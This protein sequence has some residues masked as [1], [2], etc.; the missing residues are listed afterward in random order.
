MWEPF[1]SAPTNTTAFWRGSPNERGTLNILSICIITLLL[2]AYTSLHLDIPKYDKAGWIHQLWRRLLWVCVG[3]GAPEFVSLAKW[4]TIHSTAFKLVLTPEQVA[5]IAFR[6][7]LFAR[8]LE[9][10]MHALT[11]N[12]LSNSD[13]TTPRSTWPISMLRKS[14][15]TTMAT[16]KDVEG[17]M[18][19]GTSSGPD[20]LLAEPGDR[21]SANT[22][23]TEALSDRRNIWTRVHSH[24]ALMGGFVFEADEM[25]LTIM[26]ADRKRLTLTPVALRKIAKNA[27]ELLPDLS[28]EAI[29]DK[30]K[31]NGLAKFLV[32]VQA[33]WFIAQT[34]GRLGTSLPISLLEMN[35][36]LHAFCCL[37]IYLAWWH[38]PLDIEEPHVIH[39]AN[40]YAGKVCAWMMVKDKQHGYLLAY[41]DDSKGKSSLSSS[42]RLRLV[43]EDDLAPE[44]NAEMGRNNDPA[45]M[46]RKRIAISRQHNSQEGRLEEVQQ[47]DYTLAKMS[48]KN[49]SE[50]RRVK[51]YPGQ[52]VYGF[53]I[54][55]IKATEKSAD[56]NFY[57]M[58]SILH[59]ERLRMAQSLRQ[60]DGAASAW[61]FKD[62][63]SLVKIDGKMLTEG[64]SIANL[65]SPDK[66]LTQWRRSKISS[67]NTVLSTG[68]LL[69]GSLYGGIHL[70]AWNGPFPSRIERLLW[71]ISC[72]VIASP[73]GLVL[74]T[75]AAA[76]IAIAVG[77]VLSLLNEILPLESKFSWS[78]KPIIS[79]LKTDTGTD[80][81]VLMMGGICVILA[82]I[83]A[84]A[85]MYLVVEC[86][87]NI[88]HLP[89]AVF[90]GN[91]WSQYIPHIGAG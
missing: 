74:F 35:T 3:L 79:Y 16:P 20:I 43:Y 9:Y 44:E 42:T 63:T 72:L 4:I 91:N 47:S 37:F 23:R 8:N 22:P 89:E 84:A 34:V 85:R 82:F 75:L 17:G 15:R 45:N 25:H 12:L 55:D 31:A 26:D 19:Q 65:S 88:A 18:T 53:V 28:R 2:C 33:I 40:N 60:E 13:A 39:V 62:Q 24:F 11:Q 76:Y 10:K 57:A 68:L 86:F 71:R 66:A 58:P 50:E 32:C 59:L 7:M 77:K 30:S 78:Y 56:L 27:P 54:F 49:S 46:I 52:K 80:I 14:A 73:V 61:Q 83:Y 87:I 51:L 41:K 67:P 36:L 21:R 48:A 70:F 1:G 90:Q 6:Q 38:K 5:F 69:A 64:T 29:R 81:V